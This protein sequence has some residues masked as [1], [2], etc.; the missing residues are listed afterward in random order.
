MSTGLARLVVPAQVHG[1]IIVCADGLSFWGGV[2]PDTG[3]VIDAH[4]DLCGQSLSGKIVLSF[5]PKLTDAAVLTNV[6][7]AL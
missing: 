7:N 4:H 5:E 3:R 6:R 1:D 2:D